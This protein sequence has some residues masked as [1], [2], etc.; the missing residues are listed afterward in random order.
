M[1]IKKP[2]TKPASQS[3]TLRFNYIALFIVL[4][5]ALN[6]Y[7]H[8]FE[9]LFSTAVHYQ[10]FTALVATVNFV[11]RKY[12]TETRLVSNDMAES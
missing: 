8:L 5:E 10:V 2:L 3:W 6:T 11:L 12:R 1:S 4:V 9:P 7:A